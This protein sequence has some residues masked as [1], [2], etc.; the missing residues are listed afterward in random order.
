[1]PSYSYYI[2]SSKP[3][4]FKKLRIAAVLFRDGF[5]AQLRDESTAGL[6]LGAGLVQGMK[7][8]GDIRNGIRTGIVAG[9][10]IC[11]VNGIRNVI[12]HI[13]N[14]TEIEVVAND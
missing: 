1:M 10:A 12:E 11:A 6:A 9:C 13:D 8:R 5:M 2:R 7:Y 14:V 4:S 3:M